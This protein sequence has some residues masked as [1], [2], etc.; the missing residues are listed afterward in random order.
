MHH[1]YI[2]FTTII[3][4]IKHKYITNLSDS[5]NTITSQTCHKS[6][7]ENTFQLFKYV[8]HVS[9]LFAKMVNS[10]CSNKPYLN[11][12]SRTPI[13]WIWHDKWQIK[14]SGY[15]EFPAWK[16]F[17]FTKSNK[18]EVHWLL[19]LRLGMSGFKKWR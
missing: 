16:T 9:E 18:E 6:C 5:L 7:Q 12:Q 15:T 11:V 17:I 19:S 2:D 1:T 3:R 14:N 10:R 8:N 4:F 13:T